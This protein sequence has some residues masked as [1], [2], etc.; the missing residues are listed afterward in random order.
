M[1]PAGRRPDAH[2]VLGDDVGDHQ[3]TIDETPDDNPIEID[4]FGS[5]KHH[6]EFF[7]HFNWIFILFVLSKMIFL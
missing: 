1:G 7:L 3:I 6:T 2:S 4:S 5:L